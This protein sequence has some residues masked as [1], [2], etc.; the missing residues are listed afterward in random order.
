MR[1]LGV[2]FVLLTASGA[3]A[4]PADAVIAIR[5]VTVIDGT[6]APPRPG[7]TIV[8]ERGRITLAGA[9][10]VVPTDARVVD[11]AGGFLIPGLWDMHVHRTNP[12]L[13]KLYVANGV[14]GVRDM[15]GQLPYLHGLREKIA[16]GGVIGPRIVS[17]GPIVDGK[18]PIWRG[19]IEATT[20]EEG[21]A[22]VTKLVELEADFAKVYAKLSPETHAA[23]LDEARQRGLPVAGHIPRSMTA[24]QVSI[25]GQRCIE[26]MSGFLADCAAPNLAGDRAPESRSQRIA[27]EAAAYDPMRAAA[28][29]ETLVEN[30]T[31][32][33]PTLTVGRAISSL[34][35]PEFTADAR[36]RYMAPYW[37]SFWD[38]ARDFRFKS[39]T[40]ADW[41]AQRQAFARQK[42]LV[43]EMAAA[44]V[45]LLA[46][47]DV[48]NPYCFPGFG[49]HDELALMVEAGL[50]PAQALGAATR[51]A[52]E[53]LGLLDDL[54]TVEV[55]KVAS[56][57]LLEANPLDDIR[58]TTRI[59]AVLVEGRLFDRVEIEAL[60][61]QADR[62]IP[63]GDK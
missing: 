38:P 50:T 1:A 59:A 63:R 56:L 35:D 24:T 58:N 28:L 54:G 10:V 55:G 15:F 30:G 17:T 34:D 2:L 40:T 41:N 45:R 57:V 51:D 48:G 47:T 53:F 36:V 29:L 39:Y 44:G 22:A 62:S 31:W 19:S 12:E 8:I 42:Q 13:A 52:A 9:D 4:Q 61:R 14:T 7:Q 49:L 18:D 33:C 21:R 26:H 5:G 43:G 20:P 6:G 23:I 3:A 16:A 46:G 27:R 37:V 32:V 60:L 11:G 25:S